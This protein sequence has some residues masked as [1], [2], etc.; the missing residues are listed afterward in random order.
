[1]NYLPTDNLYKFC[2]TA[3]LIIVGF[4]LYY[5]FSLIR[6]LGADIIEVS[7]EMDVAEA[8]MAFW[9]ARESTLLNIT[10]NTIARQ[11][12]SKPYPGKLE[13]DSSDELKNI[14]DETERLGRDIKI[15]NAKI[16][17]KNK[18]IE[19]LASEISGLLR[20][21]MVTGVVGAIITVYGFAFWYRCVQK[22]LDEKLKE[23]GSN[24]PA[25]ADR[26]YRRP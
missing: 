7:T 11:Q 16:K 26:A 21:G 20:F 22:P 14:R 24:Q 17:G 9:V 12:P 6:T 15:A 5:P 10:K 25:P 18:K 2:A 3:G 13:L 4:S 1:M 19:M 23:T 8:D